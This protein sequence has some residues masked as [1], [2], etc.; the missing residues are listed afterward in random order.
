LNSPFTVSKDLPKEIGS[1][2]N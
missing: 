1:F 2:F